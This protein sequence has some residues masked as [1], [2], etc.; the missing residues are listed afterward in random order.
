MRKSFGIALLVMLFV[1]TSGVWAGAVP[2]GNPSFESPVCPTPGVGCT[3]LDW[4]VVGSA[5][6]IEPAQGTYGP[7]GEG[8]QIGWANTGGVLEQ[9]LSNVVAANTTYQLSVDVGARVDLAFGAEVYLFANS[10]EVGAAT[11]V[12]PI[13]GGWSTWTL[14]FDTAN[15]LY[16]SYVGDVITIALTSTT[17][18]SGFDSVAL[19]ATPD[20]GGVSPEPAMFALVGAGLLGLVTRRRFAK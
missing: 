6:Q 15:A 18:Q 17:N 7:S 10:T 20:G 4:T 1:A 8:S 16:S 3:P 12:A 14:T 5:N 13:A 19:N 9:A 11:G 2:I